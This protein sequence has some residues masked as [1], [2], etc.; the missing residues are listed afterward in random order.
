MFIDTHAHLNL[1]NYD[2]DLDE[3]IKRAAENGVAKIICVSSNVTDSQK[4]IEIAKKYLG[5]VYAAVGI[6]PQQTDPENKTSL[7]VQLAQLVKLAES[8]SV[9][10]IGECGLDYSEAPR[11]DQVFLFEKQIET[12]K[13]FN[14]PVIVH[15]RKTFDETLA[16]LKKWQPLNGVFHCYSGGKNDIK[17]VEEIGFYLGLDGNLTYDLG[18]Q[19]VVKE[20]PL[21]KILLETD[22]PFLSPEPYR[23]LRNEPKNVK[24]IAE[25]LAKLKGISSEKI[26][27]ITTKNAQKLFNL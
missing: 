10:A 7:A 12:A 6:H 23:G 19:N 18:L 16:V 22:C 25:F 17:K 14:L 24:I 8:E 21:E 3:V 26:A 11:P 4:A 20:M 9:V 1:P 15:S 5:I 27:Q 2:K 13:K